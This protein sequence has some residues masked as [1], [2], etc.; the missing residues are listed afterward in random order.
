MKGVNGLI[1]VAIV[2][3]SRLLGREMLEEVRFLL[4]FKMDSQSP[5]ALIIAGQSELWD[6]LKLQ[7]Y[8]AI[9]QRIDMTCGCAAADTTTARRPG[10]LHMAAA[11]AAATAP[12]Y[13]EALAASMPVSSQIIV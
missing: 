1:P 12:S 10:S 6:K 8:A 5:L 9:R 11:S 2:D 7:S 13:T 3:E 4:N